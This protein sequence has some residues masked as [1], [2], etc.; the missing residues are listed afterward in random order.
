MTDPVIAVLATRLNAAGLPC[1]PRLLARYAE[2][3]ALT[4]EKTTSEDAYDAWLLW[5]ED[6]GGEP[7]P[8]VTQR[9]FDERVAVVIREV[10]RYDTP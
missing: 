7:S 3:L 2:Q 4:G 6:D 5:I 8:D 10:A 9:L 1:G